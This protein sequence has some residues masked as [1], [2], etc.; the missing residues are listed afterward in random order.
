MSSYRGKRACPTVVLPAFSSWLRCSCAHAI[1]FWKC[2]QLIQ[3]NFQFFRC[4]QWLDKLIYL[5]DIGHLGG[6]LLSLYICSLNFVNLGLDVSSQWLV[7]SLTPAWTIDS[8]QKNQNRRRPV[9]PKLFDVEL[10]QSQT[11]T[12]AWYCHTKARPRPRLGR[13]YYRFSS[14]K[15]QSIHMF[16][17]L[18]DN[19]G[20]W[21]FICILT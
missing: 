21:F 10:P 16:R 6:I 12:K 17:P 9:F 5:F 3:Y 15:N 1:L 19:L 14:I 2:W 8:W 7:L 13:L 20:S 11:K 18:P 4:W